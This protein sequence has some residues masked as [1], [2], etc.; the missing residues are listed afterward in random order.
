MKY[1]NNNKILFT[2]YKSLYTIWVYNS[3]FTIHNI[4]YRAYKK[5]KRSLNSNKLSK[6]FVGAIYLL[7]S[8]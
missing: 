3:Q 8:V 7:Q 6:I 5:E 1:N 4:L 2:I